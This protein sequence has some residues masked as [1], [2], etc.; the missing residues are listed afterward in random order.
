LKRD[1]SVALIKCSNLAIRKENWGRAEKGLIECLQLREDLNSSP[2]AGVEAMLDLAINLILLG[3][4]YRETKNPMAAMDCYNKSLEVVH[5]QGMGEVS[6]ETALY[7]RAVSMMNLAA[8]QIELTLGGEIKW[9][10]IEL[11]RVRTQLGASRAWTESLVVQA[12]AKD[13]FHLLLAEILFYQSKITDVAESEGYRLLAWKFIKT[14]RRSVI[15]KWSASSRIFED[16]RREFG[17][18]LP[19]L[20][21]DAP[22]RVLRPDWFRSNESLIPTGYQATAPTLRGSSSSRSPKAATKRKPPRKK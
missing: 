7:Y 1:L 22:D 15:R 13:E 3:G 9:N 10:S 14:I 5:G 8:I 17:N 18:D 20:Y 4:F 16:L 19:D 21:A 2:R 11:E 12:T 6:G